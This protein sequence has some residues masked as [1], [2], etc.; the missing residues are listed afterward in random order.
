MGF[1]A[2]AVQ[3]QGPLVG[4]GS[5]LPRP[6]GLI[7]LGSQT[8]GS[9]PL[10]LTP[11]PPMGPNVVSTTVADPPV[12]PTA[13]GGSTGLPTLDALM[14]REKELALQKGFTP[15]SFQS[16][17]QGAAYAADKLFQGFA[18]GRNQRD[19]LAQEASRAEILKGLDPS[20]IATPEQIAAM[21]QVDMTT[22]GQLY[23]AAMTARAAETKAGTDATK[24]AMPKETEIAALAD[25]YANVPDVKKLQNAQSMW[26][27]MQDAATRDT[28]QADL[29]M[30]IAMAKLFDP[31]S[32][33][34]T[35]EGKMVEL[36]GTAP[37][38]VKAAFMYMIGKPG[39]RLSRKTRQG[40][41]QEAFSRMTGYH[42][43]VQEAA[44]WYT[45][46]ANRRGWNP[47]DIVRPFEAPQPFDLELV[48]GS[49]TEDP[50]VTADPDKPDPT[51]PP[52]LVKTEKQP[53]GTLV[54][55]WSDGTTS[56]ERP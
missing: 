42:K 16:P 56:T 4:P 37:D 7:G 35:E 27:S 17:W 52:T 15:S 6:R 2:V 25:D 9:N 38:S 24:D 8:P 32:V 23:D 11:R 49:D 31:D 54:H 41:M 51:K 20:G 30:I 22:A 26:R 18:Q 5:T 39:S 13:G 43:G 14:Q 33:V 29:N 40:M 47:A 10:N 44:K 12:D 55:T 19:T 34:R 21:S 45:D 1:P 28:S 3:P 48:V 50:A 46:K 36:T 53:D